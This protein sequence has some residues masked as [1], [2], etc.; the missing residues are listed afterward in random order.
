MKDNNTGPACKKCND[1]GYIVIQSHN[2][3]YARPGPVP[4]D[5]RGYAEARCF[6]CLA[7]PGGADA[8]LA[9]LTAAGWTLAPP[10]S[11]VVPEGGVDA[12]TVRKCM[13]AAYTVPDYVQNFPE[14]DSDGLLQPGSPYDRGAYDARQRI[15]AL[16]EAK[17]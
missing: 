8:I 17:P 2:G 14:P 12:E 7:N 9:A 16:A 4:D 1:T 13:D 5:A 11:R 6:E 3:R 15:R 10:G